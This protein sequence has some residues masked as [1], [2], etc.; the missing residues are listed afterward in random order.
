MSSSTTSVFFSPATYSSGNK[1]AD[2][3]DEEGAALAPEEKGGAPVDG[4]RLSSALRTRGVGSLMVG[5]VFLGLLVVMQRWI[6]LDA[7]FVRGSNLL[8]SI[9]K[10]QRPPHHNISTPPLMSIPFSCGNDTA[11][12]TATCPATPLPQLSK[13]GGGGGGGATASC[14]DY[15]RY[16]HDDLRPWR[17]VGITR[18]AVERGRKHAYF[19]L[20][21][22]SG[23][24]Y[25]ETYR[26]S[27]QTR[28]VFTQWGVVQLLRR[29][30]GRLP[31]LDI[32][33]ACDDPGQVRA[34][35]FSA[36][37]AEAPPVFRYCKDKTTVD[38]VF[39]DWSFWGW[40]EVNIGPWPQML[41]EV[42]RENERVRWPEREP[43]A[44]WKGNPS[45]ARIRG[46]LMKC[47]PSNGQ[48][49]NARLFSQNWNHA[50]RNGFRDSSIPKQC[51]HRYKIYIEGEAWSVSEKYILACDSPVL[52][53]TTPFQDMLSRAL[54]AGEH[55][56]PINRT[57]MCESIKLAVDWG[58]RHPAT[59]QL[60]GEQGS[61][62]VR[63][64]MSMDYVYDYMLHLLTEYGKLLRYKPTVPEKAVEICTT[65]M[66][67]PA[68]ARHRECMDESVEKFVAGFGPCTLPP[69]FNAEEAMEIADREEKVLRS[70]E[71]MEKENSNS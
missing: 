1:K 31:D 62:F 29:Y 48:D 19:R 32:M 69:P 5:L 14:P 23:R 20:V 35:D 2:D 9:S 60:I 42:Q 66:A 15:F 59:A 12:A 28:D 34:A 71:E 33:F 43:F 26:R 65:S 37:P 57:H 7:S 4:R 54:V 40:P 52:F 49:W 16:I 8:G 13:P 41:E 27:Y 3:D 64:Q 24:A 45:V 17:G 70:V 51:L 63:E 55:Y 21:V 38:I 46:D 39:P 25:V 56:W 44:F 30:A 6:G 18:E 10:R 68:K 53:V 61:R 22:V 11:A 47:N 36:A 58:N 50:I 67:C